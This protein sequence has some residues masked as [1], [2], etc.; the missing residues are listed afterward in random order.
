[1]HLR[2]DYQ[3]CRGGDKKERRQKYA[4]NSYLPHFFLTFASLLLLLFAE[5]CLLLTLHLFKSR[6]ET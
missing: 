4:K 1:M 5:H 6:H 3:V 2:S